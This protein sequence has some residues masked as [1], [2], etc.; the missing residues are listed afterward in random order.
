MLTVYVVAC[1]AIGFLAG[2]AVT[3]L[4]PG[5][6][7]SRIAKAKQ[8]EADAKLLARHADLEFARLRSQILS[9]AKMVEAAAAHAAQDIRKEL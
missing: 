2:V 1:L 9:K 3:N 8:A 4:W 7:N 5:F 6:V